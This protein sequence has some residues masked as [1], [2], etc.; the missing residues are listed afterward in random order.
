M[1]ITITPQKLGGA[2]SQSAGDFVNY[3]EKEN[4]GKDPLDKEYFFNQYEDKIK[5]YQ[6]I[7]EIDGNTAKLKLKEPKYYSI[8]INPSQYEL[9]HIHNNPEKLRAF[10]REAM[11]EYASSFHREINGKP[12]NVDD[13]KYFAKLEHERTY[14]SNDIAIRENKPY[15]NQIAHLKNELR[16]VERGEVLGNALQIEKDIRKLVR[17]APYKI[18]GQVVEPGMKKEG[19]QSHIHIIVSRKDASNSYSLSPGSKYKASEVKMHGKMVKR[20]FE[21]DRFIQNSEKA[22]DRLFQY[23]RNYVESYAA[24]KMLTKDPKQYFLSLGKLGINEK[25]IAF[26]MIRQTGL[27]LP[28]LHLPQNKVGFAYKQLKKIIEASVKASSIGY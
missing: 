6:V 28:V 19:S 14:K 22:F 8:T 7:K 23:N 16:K 21:R 9:K 18:R 4:Q 27:Q 12:I 5:P 11:K 15:S 2:F 20:G 26:K 1:Y 13:I 3:L 10:V 24:K 25:K 17:E